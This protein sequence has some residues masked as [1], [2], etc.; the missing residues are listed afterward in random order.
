MREQVLPPVVSSDGADRLT[1]RHAD[2]SF[3]DALL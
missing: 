3:D 2:N 1:R